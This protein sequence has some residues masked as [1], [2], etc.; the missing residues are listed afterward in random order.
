LQKKHVLEGSG[1][2]GMEVVEAALHC[3]ME[4][5]NKKI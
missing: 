5:I 1:R 3:G 2:K 4:I